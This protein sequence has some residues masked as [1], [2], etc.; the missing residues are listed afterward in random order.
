MIAIRMQR[1]IYAWFS[2]YV[3]LESNYKINIQEEKLPKIRVG[4]LTLIRVGFLHFKMGCREGG[5][6]LSTSFCLKFVE[7]MLETWNLVCEYTQICSFIK[8][9]F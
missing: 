3:N 9:T 8:N 6:K 1:W 5:V 4:S 2:Y 7:I